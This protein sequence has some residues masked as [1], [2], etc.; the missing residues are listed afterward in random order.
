MTAAYSPQ[1]DWRR[2]DREAGREFVMGDTV[3]IEPGTYHGAARPATAT[4]IGEG[5]QPGTFKVIRNG[6]HMT[7]H[8]SELTNAVGAS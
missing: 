7:F 8:A 2:D 3:H 5:A 6:W 1:A 4:I